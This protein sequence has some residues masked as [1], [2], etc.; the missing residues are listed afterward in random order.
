MR[1]EVAPRRAAVT[2]GQPQPFTVT[3]MNTSTVIGGYV[4]RVLGADPSWVQLDTDQV[5]MFPEE[6]RTVSVVITV[7]KGIPA[8]AR[9]VA[10]QVRELTPPHATTVHEIDLTVP[11]ARSAT[12]R[13]DP[14][15]V[16]AGRAA[17]F[18]VLVENSGN[19]IVRADLAAED[20]EGKVRFEFEP[21]RV[22]LT[23]GEH[24][25]VDMVARARRPTIGSPAPRIISLFLDEVADDPFFAPNAEAARPAHAE[26]D[27]VATGTFVQRSLLSRGPLSLLGLIAAI[28]VFAIVI[29]IAMSRLVGQSAADRN[30]ALQIAA[31][32]ES[33]AAV[34]TSGLGGVVRLLTSHRPISGVSVAVYDASDTSI[35]IGTT[36]TDSGGNYH[37]SN[38]SAGQ[39]KLA[40]RGADFLQLW[41]PS[42]VTAADAST[43]RLGA[44]Q[45]R[46]GLDVT[47]GGIPATISGKVN[48]DDLAGATLYLERPVDN[49][50]AGGG[51]V[52]VP[53]AVPGA[54]PGIPPDTGD[55]IVKTVPIG[56]DG[57]FTLSDV[58][59]PNTYLLV[60]AKPG[61]AT[62][63]QTINV[64]A[65]EERSSVE[66][67]L[68]KGDGLISGLVA[69]SSGRQLGD[70]TV[71]A[72]TGTTSASTVSLTE[73]PAGSFTLRNLPTPGT[74][75]LVARKPGYAAQT[76]TLTLAAGQKLTGVSV[77]L[78]HSSGSLSGLVT[79]V[80]PSP[81][82]DT[83][84]AGVAVSVTDGQLTVQTE[85]Q[86]VA[87]VGSWKI[88]GLPLPGT[89]TM[90]F[91]RADLASQTLSVS[92][93]ALGNITG[94][95]QSTAV[96]A[97]SVNVRMRSATA[98]VEGTI[99]QRDGAAVCDGAN[100]LG[101]ALVTLNSG[102][103]T[104][105]VTSASRPVGKCGQY[106]IENV[107]PGT[108]TLTVSAGAGTVP[109]SRIVRLGVGELAEEPVRL[110]RP[111]SMSG[112][113]VSSTGGGRC[114]WTVF[115]YLA[116]EFP[117]TVTA[118]ARTRGTNPE[119]CG[120]FTFS[121][122]DAGSYILAVGPTSDPVNAV[123][124]VSVTVHPSEQ[125][126][127]PA[128]GTSLVIKAD[129]GG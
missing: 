67:V 124:T 77:T 25:V 119:T 99:T 128:D 113:V 34:G 8:G 106:R 109:D 4:I 74:Y 53:P 36:A 60:L 98:I 69:S 84:A 92:L 43:I 5:S 21:E 75:T 57:T 19:T 41:Y 76:M 95:S 127:T 102:S 68:R 123:V 112:R 118:R 73:N 42:A 40:F 45:V 29:T 94:G 22:V 38:L 122:I 64:G 47:V 52:V 39:Y 15:M 71:T 129:P 7:P 115:L 13:L 3:I 50:S 33:G 46:T 26:D 30:L 111:A 24:T 90:T 120:R 11:S 104:F 79:V 125:Y 70:V 9:R 105:T 80:H 49:G 35:P 88:G 31:A 97:S 78:H 12:A 116:S 107:P 117:D 91:T 63:S 87:P 48:G 6:S 114:G 83:P 85:T 58:P 17:R 23:P 32:R 28:T 16:T 14:I 81:Q 37:L 86:S 96:T 18:T 72:T 59:S 100:H 108:Y 93:D 66:L 56:S 55:A 62:S 54:A 27:I 82:Q 20:P 65:G 61:Y 51:S 110:A 126:G 10:V 103:V 2:P 1:V 101:E 89:Y 44:G 121:R